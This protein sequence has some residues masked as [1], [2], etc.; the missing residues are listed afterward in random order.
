M[1][2]DLFVF[3]EHGSNVAKVDCMAEDMDIGNG[4]GHMVTLATSTKC[5]Y[6]QRVQ[7]CTKS[8]AIT[9]GRYE[10]SEQNR[11]HDPNTS[12]MLQD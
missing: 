11:M 4:A 2:K 7:K 6:L 5:I 8:F 3:I 9:L 12:S 1:G 10:F